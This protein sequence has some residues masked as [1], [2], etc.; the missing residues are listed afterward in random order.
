MLFNLLIED[1]F[2]MFPCLSDHM[3]WVIKHDAVAEH[4]PHVR[5]ELLCAIVTWIVGVGIWLGRIRRDEL[6]V[7]RSI[8]F[9]IMLG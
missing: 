8:G 5:N 1:R 2:N 6:I 9:L 3:I 4:Q 7:P